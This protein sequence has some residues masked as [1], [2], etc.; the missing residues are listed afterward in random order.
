[1]QYWGYFCARILKN[2][3]HISNQYPPICLMAIFFEKAK[4]TK[5]GTK[6]AVIADFWTRILKNY[7]DIINQHPQVCLFA[8]FHEKTNMAKFGTKSA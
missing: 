2:Y 5:F 3:C 6:N 8:K 7:C 1:M 4:V